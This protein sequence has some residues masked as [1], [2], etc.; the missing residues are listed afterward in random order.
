M[1]FRALT[2]LL[3]S[4]IAGLSAPPPLLRNSWST[5]T[6]GTPVR[7]V[8]NLSATNAAVAG[9]NWQFFGIGPATIARLTDVSNMVSLLLNP[10]QFSSSGNISSIKD[11]AV[12][13]NINMVGITNKGDVLFSPD[14][15]FDIGKGGLTR[16]RNITAS[17]SITNGG[18]I[19]SVGIIIGGNGGSQLQANGIRIAT[20]SSGLIQ[21]NGTGFLK[22]PS[23]GVALLQNDAATSFTRLIFGSNH[24]AFASWG[25]TNGNF[26][27]F[28]GNGL[29]GSA[30][31]TNG[32]TSDGS[33][34]YPSNGNMTVAI[35]T[36]SLAN[37]D[38][39]M[40]M[41]SNRLQAVCMSNSAVTFKVLAP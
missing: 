40:G 18:T 38:C 13:T 14:A 11:G 34:Y 10:L 31:A 17:G 8:D 25:Y 26:R 33:Y 20:G 37:G 21:F 35:I 9:T 41:L 4:C 5:N 3:L 39:W 23:D 16:P 32:I 6:A 29:Y 12:Q 19:F 24:A 22:F 7:G 27:A 30:V 36:A 2:I 28:G 15:T 1:M